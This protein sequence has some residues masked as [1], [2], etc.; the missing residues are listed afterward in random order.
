MPSDIPSLDLKVGP[1]ESGR[2][3]P[4]EMVMCDF[5]MHA[6]GIGHT[7]KFWCAVAP[8]DVVK[9]RYRPQNGKLY[10]LVAASR[11]FWALGF[12]ADRVY[13]VKVA[14]RGCTADPWHIHQESP[15]SGLLLFDPATIDRGMRGHTLETKPHEGWA[16]NELDY[17]DEAA[18][19]APPAQ[20]DA[21]KLLAVFVQ[22]TDTKS[23]NQSL[24]CLD[25][26]CDRP[27]MVAH[28]LGNTFGH[29]DIYNR[30]GPASVNFRNWSREPI[31][32]GK[33]KRTCIG[34]LPRSMTGTL[35]D[36]HISEEGRKFLADLL[37]Q[38]SDTQLRDLFEVARFAA[39]EPDR[40]VDDWV[41]VFK[42]KRDEIVNTTCA[43]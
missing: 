24:L 8:G 12:G 34:N 28:D 20:R 29:A 42:R 36:P 16:W 32:R 5:A 13:P 1:D 25:A 23:P 6:R 9:V 40:S 18:G 4:D 19:G 41:S 26:A 2:F 38:L 14:C 22:H 11:L 10:G 21:L 35:G 37:V 30:D 7:A 39:R 27:F 31:W 33:D 15:I 3:M 43:Q 17:V